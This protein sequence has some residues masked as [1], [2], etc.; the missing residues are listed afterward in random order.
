M[1][2][3]FKQTAFSTSGLLTASAIYISLLVFAGH[4]GFDKLPSSLLLSENTVKTEPSQKPLIQP[5]AAG[6]FQ[7][8]TLDQDELQPADVAQGVSESERLNPQAFTEISKK[9]L[10]HQ[11]ISS[12]VYYPQVYSYPSQYNQALAQY[13]AVNPTT[14]TRWDQGH[15]AVSRANGRGQGRSRGD[16]EMTFSM[17]FKSRARMDA[18]MDAHSE[19]DTY[20]DAALRYANDAYWNPSYSAYSRRY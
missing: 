17:R 9:N 2:S 3:S 13:Y 6:I 4:Y 10:D 16:G 12:A 7:S 8:A 20:H 15:H 19:A 14:S 1:T 11:Q 18:D 5:S